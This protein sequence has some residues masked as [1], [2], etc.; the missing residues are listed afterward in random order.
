MLIPDSGNGGA[1]VAPGQLR[2]DYRHNKLCV[3]D[4]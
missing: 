2:Q 1:K 4:E 3:S